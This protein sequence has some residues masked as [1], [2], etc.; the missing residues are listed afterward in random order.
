MLHVCTRT[1]QAV[2]KRDH[3]YLM[4]TTKSGGE[5]TTVTG[6]LQMTK[7]WHRTIGCLFDGTD[8]GLRDAIP[9]HR[10]PNLTIQPPT[11]SQIS[12]HSRNRPHSP[13]VSGKIQVSE[14]MWCCVCLV[15]CCKL[16]GWSVAVA[17]L[18]VGFDGL[19]SILYGWNMPAYEW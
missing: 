4:S 11:D 8:Y 3:H 16:Q 17:N 19:H 2:W 15:V 9:D 14:V 7:C 13:Q 10:H 1:S 12:R 5:R 18:L 6:S